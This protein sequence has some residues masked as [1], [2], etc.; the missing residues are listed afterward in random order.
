MCQTP[1]NVGEVVL[2]TRLLSMLIPQNTF[3]TIKM[4]I[5]NIRIK[6]INTIFQIHY[7]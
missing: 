5:V 4:R 2:E 3:S 7:W 1:I 6:N